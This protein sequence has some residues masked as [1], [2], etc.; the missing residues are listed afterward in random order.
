MTKTLEVIETVWN[1]VC[2]E[3]IE[4][5]FEWIEIFFEYVFYILKWVCWAI[6]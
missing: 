6:D 1:W 2:H 5:I 3:V 4:T